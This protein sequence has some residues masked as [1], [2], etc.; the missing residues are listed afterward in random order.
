VHGVPVRFG[1]KE[2]SK[3]PVTSGIAACREAP[4]D[5]SHPQARVGGAARPASSIE[6]RLG[7]RAP[8][9]FAH[10]GRTGGGG[11]RLRPR[12]PLWGRAPPRDVARLTRHRG[13]RVGVHFSVPAEGQG[14][15]Q[16]AREV[17]DPPSSSKP[18]GPRPD[19]RNA[20]L[21]IRAL[22]DRRD[23]SDVMTLYEMFGIAGQVGGRDRTLCPLRPRTRSRPPPWSHAL[24][25]TPTRPPPPLPRRRRGAPRG[26]GLP[27]GPRV[28]RRRRS[29]SAASSS[30]PGNARP[31]AAATAWL[32]GSWRCFPWW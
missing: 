16:G 15:P 25:P 30:R 19:P 7:C 23:G 9:L 22:M 20:T 4:P 1:A 11:R 14:Q 12:A 17:R 2:R 21:P 28:P 18:A 27:Q 24:P 8:G 32:T 6:E 5:L 29:A 31:A 10:W 26:P 3:R 13:G